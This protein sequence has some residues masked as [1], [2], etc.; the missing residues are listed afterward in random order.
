MD[1]IGGRSRLL[2]FG[3][4]IWRD[5]DVLPPVPS[6]IEVEISNQ[7]TAL[8]IDQQRL[9]EAV[10]LVLRGEGVE[11]AEI[12]LAIVDDPTIHA[13]NRQ[14]LDHDYPTDVLSFELS[15]G[16]GLL[17]GEVIVSAE[18][19]FRQAAQF[20]WTAGDELL[21]YTIHGVLHLAGHDDHTPEQRAA[22]RTRE[23]RYLEH[24]G[25]SPRYDIDAAD[26]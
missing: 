2:H 3:S 25:L 14:H 11:Q 12:S 7:Q 26:E 13:L 18:T 5:D 1:A 17:E 4:Q 8:P 19:A 24:F 10:R 22:M 15:R 23:A 9:V 21:L 20:G 6:V 16:E